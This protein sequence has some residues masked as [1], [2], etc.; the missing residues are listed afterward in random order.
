LVIHE[1]SRTSISNHHAAQNAQQ[2]EVSERTIYRDIQALSLSGM[3]IESET[4]VGY[5]LK[6]GFAIAP[7]MFEPEELEA[8]IL[9]ARMVQG[10]SGDKLVSAADSAFT[11][12]KAVLPESLHQSY[13]MEP[14]WLIVPDFHQS[15]SSVFS[16][17]IRQAIK[18]KQQLMLVYEDELKRASSR[19]VWPL[20][21]VF[22]GRNWT[23]VA[24]CTLRNDYRTFRLDRI[25]NLIEL[26]DSFTTTT[27][28]NLHFY[29]DLQA[30]NNS[31]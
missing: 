17:D 4:G 22:W 10:W 21:L 2:L 6:S 7:L 28:I 1:K 8:L 27:E 30:Q 14:E 18:N 9:G 23:L 25:K 13:V 11:K 24:W 12:I 5:K 19:Q 15:K 3:P 26:N 31:I 16:D 29:L 20:G